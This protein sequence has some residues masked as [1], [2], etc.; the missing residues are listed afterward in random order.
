MTLFV[1]EKASF[2]LMNTCMEFLFHHNLRMRAAINN[3]PGD[4]F[5]STPLWLIKMVQWKLNET[6]IKVDCII[7]R[8]RFAFITQIFAVRNDFSLELDATVGTQLTFEEVSKHF[9]TLSAVSQ[10]NSEDVVAAE[11]IWGRVG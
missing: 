6:N 4:V 8:L 1:A 7:Y 11:E 10:T 5:L 2:T 9:L 3:L